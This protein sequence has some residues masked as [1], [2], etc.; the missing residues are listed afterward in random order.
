MYVNNDSLEDQ[1]A[2]VGRLNKQDY[3][4]QGGRSKKPA[5]KSSSLNLVNVYMYTEDKLGRIEPFK[6]FISA[7][8]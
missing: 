6:I 2:H 5:G 8:L 3:A 4:D 7:Q 1:L